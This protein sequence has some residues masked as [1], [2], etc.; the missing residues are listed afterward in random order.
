MTQQ[1]DKCVA[2]CKRFTGGE[3]RHHKHCPFY[4][5]SLSKMY[6][7][8]K[9]KDCSNRQKLLD[10][11]AKA[12]MQSLISNPAY[13]YADDGFISELAYNVADAMMQERERRMKR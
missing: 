6:D 2:G 9:Q 4:P 5:D 1:E 3:V 13:D 11:F 7:E 8:M 12:A 10:D